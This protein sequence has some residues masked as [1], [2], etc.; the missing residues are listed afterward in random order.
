MELGTNRHMPLGDEH[1]GFELRPQ[2]RRV[3]A[4]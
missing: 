1:M 4:R 2:P 3:T